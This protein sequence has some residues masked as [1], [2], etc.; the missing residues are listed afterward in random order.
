M[1]SSMKTKAFNHIWPEVVIIL[2]FIKAKTPNKLEDET[3]F[4]SE[5]QLKH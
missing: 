5:M 1:Y 2:I 3:H 4:L